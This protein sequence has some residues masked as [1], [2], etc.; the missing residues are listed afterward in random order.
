MLETS[1]V[2]MKG[3]VTIPISIRKMLGINKG[4]IVVFAK[5]G[6]NV[7]L[8]N[9]NRLAFKEFQRDMAGEAERVGWKDERDVVDYCQEIRRELWESQHENNA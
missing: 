8:L 7:V 2:S 4:D 5:K 3:Q 1:R 9:S 6:E